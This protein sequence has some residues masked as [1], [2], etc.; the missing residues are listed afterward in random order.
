[1]R[2]TGRCCNHWDR[3]GGELQA[4]KLHWCGMMGFY[5]ALQGCEGWRSVCWARWGDNVG[6]E[7]RCVWHKQC[8]A[9]V[10]G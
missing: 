2:P 3:D 4:F 1:M 5:G 6:S 7:A 9:W 10:G 8:Q